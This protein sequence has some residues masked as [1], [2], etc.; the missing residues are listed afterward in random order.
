MGL[1]IFDGDHCWLQALSPLCLYPKQNDNEIIT[2]I[3]K[4]ISIFT[5]PFRLLTAI[6]RGRGKAIVNSLPEYKK[7]EPKLKRYNQCTNS[8]GLFA[9]D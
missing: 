4:N 7:M 9:L 5:A 8:C 1:V 3:R 2:K 6:K